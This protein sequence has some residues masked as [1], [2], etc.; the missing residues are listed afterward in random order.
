MLEQNLRGYG[1]FVD[2]HT[3]GI[4]NGISNGR[5]VTLIRERASLPNPL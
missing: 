5:L 2:G 1:K 3:G 4:Q